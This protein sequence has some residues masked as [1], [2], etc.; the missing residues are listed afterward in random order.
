MTCRGCQSLFDF[1]SITADDDKLR[2]FF[3]AHHVVAGVRFCDTCHEECR[4]VRRRKLFRCDRQVTVKLHGGVPRSSE[5]VHSQR[6][7]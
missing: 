2:D 1:A 5:S 3:V 6:A 4:V 7:W